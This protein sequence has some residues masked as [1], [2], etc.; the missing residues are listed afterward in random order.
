M[1]GKCCNKCKQLKDVSEF[2]KHT[3]NKDGLDT[4]CKTC[5]KEYADAKREHIKE[6][7]RKSYYKN[8]EKEINEARLYGYK[9][10][11]TVIPD[12]LVEFMNNHRVEKIPI[13]YK[14]YRER[15]GKRLLEYKRN[16]KEK[17]K[18][19]YKKYSATPRGKECNR[20]KSLR[21]RARKT[22]TENT[23]TTEEVKFLYVLQSGKCGCCGKEFS[24]II[25]YELDHI[26]P[27]ASGGGLTL[28]NT[29]LLCRSCNASK[30]SKTIRY[31]PSFIF[32]NSCD[33][34]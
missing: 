21:R 18:L 17:M 11:G 30:G 3:R 23:L 14:E 16:N 32:S 19:E 27:V 26:V 6:L 1:T 13:R 22:N 8:R 5:I 20:L 12:D 10:R 33:C 31:I 34:V 7:G 4:H 2:S 25:K 29:Q 28:G 9:Q 24:N 15:D